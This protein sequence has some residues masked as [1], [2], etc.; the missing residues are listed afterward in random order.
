M[1][2]LLLPN[3]STHNCT[4]FVLAVHWIISLLIFKYCF[5]LSNKFLLSGASHKAS[6]SLLFHAGLNFMLHAVKAFYLFI[7]IFIIIRAF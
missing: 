4:C 5:F 6:A 3:V 2:P 7:F 1:E